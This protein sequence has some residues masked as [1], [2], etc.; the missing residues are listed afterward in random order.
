[1][2]S[3]YGGV[4]KP[5]IRKTAPRFST[6]ARTDRTG[7]Q[8]SQAS[9]RP[10]KPHIQ[11]LVKPFEVRE[12]ASVSTKREKDTDGGRGADATTRGDHST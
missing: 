9:A 2:A 3:A 6:V 4:A 12:E 5:R 8:T 1:M 11:S 10:S 7:L